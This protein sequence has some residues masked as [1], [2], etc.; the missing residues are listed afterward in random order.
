M[1]ELEL[2]D[3]VVLELVLEDDEL[4]VVLDVV[5]VDEVVLTVVDDEDSRRRRLA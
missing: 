5:L 1:D 3:D 4:D 2:D